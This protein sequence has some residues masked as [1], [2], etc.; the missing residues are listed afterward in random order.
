[1]MFDSSE[2]STDKLLIEESTLKYLTLT[3]WGIPTPGRSSF[4][5]H[6]GTILLES[7]GLGRHICSSHQLQVTAFFS[8]LECRGVKWCNVSPGNSRSLWHCKYVRNSFVSKKEN[9]YLR[10]CILGAYYL[11]CLKENQEQRYV[12][13]EDRLPYTRVNSIQRII[14]QSNQIPSLLSSYTEDRKVRKLRDWDGEI[15]TSR[16]VEST[17]AS[18]GRGSYPQRRQHRRRARAEEGE[19]WRRINGVN[20]LSSSPHAV[21]Q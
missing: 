14:N 10:C 1:M 11:G 2:D 6:I 17:R 7:Q 19:N 9:N 3:C 21:F 13:V 8:L 5:W 15:G 18:E 20:L 16:S 12:W 4:R